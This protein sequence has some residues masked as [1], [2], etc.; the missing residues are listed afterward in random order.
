[1]VRFFFPD[2]A[3]AADG[4]AAVIDL[5]RKT[6]YDFS[7]GPLKPAEI[8]ESGLWIEGETDAAVDILEGLPGVLRSDE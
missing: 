4:L 6:S 1:M 3:G 8:F 2:P 5:A 7:F